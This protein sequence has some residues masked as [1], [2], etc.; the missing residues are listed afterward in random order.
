MTSIL[1]VSEIQDPT[2]SNTALTINSTGNLLLPN[3]PSFMFTYSGANWT[4]N[5]GLAG[6]HYSTGVN[7]GSPAITWDDT[8]GRLIVPLTGLYLITFGIL[9][10]TGG[11]RLEG[12][13]Q[14]TTG[15][16]NTSVVNFNG[17]GTTYDGPTFT[18]VYP[19]SANDYFGIIRSSGT[20]YAAAHGNNFFG[21]TFLG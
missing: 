14:H 9:V 19:A 1:K 20:A 8:N 15:S 12:Y 6:S 11:G 10:N 16:T 13:L 18:V 2:N 7:E 4:T 17:T 21:A 5:S 3:R